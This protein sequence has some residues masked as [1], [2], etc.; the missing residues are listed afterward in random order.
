[1][2]HHV[3]VFLIDSNEKVKTSLNLMFDVLPRIGEQICIHNDWYPFKLQ[4]EVTRVTHICNVKRAELP[5]EISVD[6]LGGRNWFYHVS[7]K[8]VDW[9]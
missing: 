6:F 5:E 8:E 2:I 9:L 3:T 7:I 4:G 1:M